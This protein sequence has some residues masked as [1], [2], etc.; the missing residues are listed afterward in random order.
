MFIEAWCFDFNFSF[1]RKC[2]IYLFIFPYAYNRLYY[3]KGNS[4][5]QVAK[6]NYLVVNVKKS[7]KI[8]LYYL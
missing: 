1:V 2:S 5:E 6:K 8:S 7:D 4:F 3:D